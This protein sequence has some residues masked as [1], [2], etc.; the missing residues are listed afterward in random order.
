MPQ[1]IAGE[2]EIQYHSEDNTEESEPSNSKHWRK[3]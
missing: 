1:E 2:I 3:K